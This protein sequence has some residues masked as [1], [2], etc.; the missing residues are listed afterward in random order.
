ME[1]WVV[2]LLDVDA[3]DDADD[4]FLKVALDQLCEDHSLLGDDRIGGGR[5]DHGDRKAE[6][7]RRVGAQAP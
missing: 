2:E 3:D 6:Q 4:A 5:D 1:L 7:H